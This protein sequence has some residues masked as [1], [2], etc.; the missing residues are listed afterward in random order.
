MLANIIVVSFMVLVAGT[1][2]SSVLRIG[3]PQKV[4]TPPAAAGVL[5]I[6]AAQFAGL[7]YVMMVLN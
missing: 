6:C 2:L 3:K 7:L 4:V 5:I 1:A